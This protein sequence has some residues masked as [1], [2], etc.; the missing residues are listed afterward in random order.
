[1][2]EDA[3]APVGTVGEGGQLGALVYG[4]GSR[5]VIDSQA[6]LVAF[7]VVEGL[8]MRGRVADEPPGI[9]LP[10]RLARRGAAVPREASQVAA[11][12]CP[13]RSRPDTVSV[14]PPLRA[15]R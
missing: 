13:R 4:G 9:E 11:E 6:R 3:V 12:P 15:H 10:A 2:S 7:D 1:M 14:D 8:D 5:H